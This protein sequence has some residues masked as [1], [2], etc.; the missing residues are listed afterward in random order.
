MSV[1]PVDGKRLLT[2]R[3]G[4]EFRDFDL[5]EQALTHRSYG[6]EHNER[7][8][9]LGDSIVNF[10]IGET[11][12]Q[13]FPEAR[14]G[15]LSRMRARLVKGSTLAAIAR[16]YQVGDCLNLG[17]GELKSGGHRRESILADALEALVGAMYLDGGLETCRRRILTW[18]QERLLKIR[19]GDVNKDAKTRLQEW[20]QAR[21][22]PLPVYHLCA[23]HGEEHN[24][25]F[26]VECQVAAIEENF[27][28]SGGSRRAAE[29]AAAAAALSRLQELP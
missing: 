16:E 27:K 10:V 22:Q 18:Y 12:Y 14:E 5:V 6:G 3:L 1:S 13:Q 28:G 11:L 29:Q 8:E 25:Q 26:E 4:Y 23:A 19:P 9:F 17:P 20:L 24:Q 7:L 21:R 15:D 2:Q